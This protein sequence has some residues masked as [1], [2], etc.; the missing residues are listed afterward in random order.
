MVRRN[1]KFPDKPCLHCGGRLIS[2][3]RGLCHRCYY[4]VEIRERYE[5]LDPELAEKYLEHGTG[6]EPALTEPT[7][8]TARPGTPEKVEVMAARAARGEW[9]FHP[10]DAR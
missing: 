9:L 2:R 3:P 4:D 5:F 1:K 10:L 6:L 8:T 7:P